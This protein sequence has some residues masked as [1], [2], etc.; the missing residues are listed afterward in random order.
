MA[1]QSCRKSLPA[2]AKIVG[3]Y[4]LRRTGLPPAVGYAEITPAARV[5]KDALAA[6]A[7]INTRNSKFTKLKES[8]RGTL[9]PRQVP[10]LGDFRAT[11]AKRGNDAAI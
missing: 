1:S 5:A 10:A 4:F 7:L 6:H 9:R 2:L 11:F 3:S 8:L